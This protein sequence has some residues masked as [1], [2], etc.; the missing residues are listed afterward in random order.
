MNENPTFTRTKQ[1]YK[2]KSTNLEDGATFFCR[3]NDQGH[4]KT[5]QFWNGNG[6]FLKRE[7]KN[8][9][10]DD[11]GSEAEGRIEKGKGKRDA[12]EFASST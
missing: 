6:E 10:G 3:K 1:S 12:L 7:K 9:K 8:T 5:A 11:D 2:Q 4:L